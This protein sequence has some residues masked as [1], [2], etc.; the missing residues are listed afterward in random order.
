VDAFCESIGFTVEQ[1]SRVFREAQSLGLPIR[2]HGD[3]LN[4]LGCGKLAASFGA[5]SCDHCEYTSEESIEAMAAAGTVAVL[6]PSANY[7]IKEKKKPPVEGFRKAGVAMAIGC[8]T[9]PGSSPT[10]SLLLNLNMACTLLGMMPE[11]AVAG[12]TRN[13]A[14]AIG[15]G[16]SHG[17]LE[18]GKVADLC[19]WDCGEICELAYYLGFNQLNAVYKEGDLVQ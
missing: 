19:V 10:T 11:E 17:T 13:A 4:D 6:L 8:N 12:V 9:N 7:F 2:L 1:T 3:Q 18:E 16:D 5:L 15:L 14:K